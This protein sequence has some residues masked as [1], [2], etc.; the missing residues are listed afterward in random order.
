MLYPVVQVPTWKVVL[1]EKLLQFRPLDLLRVD[2]FALAGLAGLAAQARYDSVL[3]DVIT[4]GSAAVLLVRIVLGYQRMA[5]RW[6]GLGGSG[7][8]RVT[9]RRLGTLLGKGR[10]AG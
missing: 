3:V 8:G 9:E 6:A 5:D 7:W 10:C 4:F 1:P 2:L